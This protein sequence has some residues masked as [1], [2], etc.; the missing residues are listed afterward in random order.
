[1]CFDFFLKN[2]PPKAPGIKASK[3]NISGPVGGVVLTFVGGKT[4]GA[5][6]GVG[7]AVGVGVGLTTF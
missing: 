5:G 3:G 4:A 1:L 6:A 2:I 7:I